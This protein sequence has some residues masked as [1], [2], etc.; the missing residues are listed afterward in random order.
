[1]TFRNGVVGVDICHLVLSL[2]VPIKM[3]GCSVFRCKKRSDT[4]SVQK[5]NVTFHLFPKDPIR[6]QNWIKACGNHKTWLPKRTSKICSEHFHASCFLLLSNNKRKLTEAATPTLKLP[7]L[8]LDV[9][10]QESSNCRTL[11]P[12]PKKQTIETGGATNSPCHTSS[13]EPQSTDR[14]FLSPTTSTI[15]INQESPREL[16]LQKIIRQKNIKIKRLQSKTQYLKKKVASLT[17]ILHELSEK[18]LIEC[19]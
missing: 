19:D 14:I 9:D 12:P 10:S 18:F 16:K 15:N 2:K 8:L 4:S 11:Q 5:D 3:T 7:L 17:E 1:M 6:R 13:S